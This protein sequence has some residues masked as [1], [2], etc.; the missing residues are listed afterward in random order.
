MSL[1]ALKSGSNK[2]SEETFGS[3]L[4]ETKH[5]SRQCTRILGV[6]DSLK[7]E[8]NLIQYGRVKKNLIDVNDKLAYITKWYARLEEQMTNPND[9]AIGEIHKQLGFIRRDFNKMKYLTL[10][11]KSVNEQLEK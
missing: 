8:P 4:I 1:K 2:G 7:K 9:P 6:I 3:V 11:L 5:L 10:S